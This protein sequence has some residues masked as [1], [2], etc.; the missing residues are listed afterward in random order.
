MFN[1]AFVTINA[2]VQQSLIFLLKGYQVTIRPFLGPRCRFYPSCSEY[3]K[4]ALCEYG[5]LKGLFLSLRRLLRCHPFNPGG[6]DPV[7]TPFEH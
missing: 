4:T 7:P 1:R 3:S 6:Y 5:V 2:A